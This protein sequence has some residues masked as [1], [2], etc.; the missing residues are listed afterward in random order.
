MSFEADDKHVY[1]LFTKRC[2]GTPRNQRQYVWNKRNWQE[3]FD[4]VLLVATGKEATHFIGSI[5]LYKEN[6]RKNGISYFTI[7]DFCNRHSTKR[8]PSAPMQTAA[9][10]FMPYSIGQ[11]LKILSSALSIVPALANS[12]VSA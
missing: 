9:F 4:D 7:V 3:L 10:G 11:S 1:D 8:R 2:Y 12:S 5:V 6:D